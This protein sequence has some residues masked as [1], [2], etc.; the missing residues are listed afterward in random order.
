M[1]SDMRR[2]VQECAICQMHRRAPSQPP[3]SGHIPASRP[4]QAWVVDVLH[5]TPS[6]KGHEAVLVAVGVFSRYCILMPMLTIDSEEATELFKLYV[7]N[8]SGGAMER[9]ITDGGPEFK[10]EFEEL[11]RHQNIKHAVSAPGN[12]ASH[13]MVER[14]IA[15][16]EITLA[17]FIDED[18]SVWHKSL[19]DAQAVHNRTPHPALATS[20]TKA[21]SPAEVFLGRKLLSKLDADL[22][23]EVQAEEYDLDDYVKQLQSIAP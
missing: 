17:H 23:T 9:V 18:M 10:G 16:T 2:H 11:C 19:A 8:G 13:G 5:M 1:Y 22:Q 3:I 6:E 12:A 20:L 14:L 4:G 15:T 21:Y 7:L